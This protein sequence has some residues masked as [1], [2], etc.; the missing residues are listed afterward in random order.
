MIP[1]HFEPYETHEAH[2]QLQTHDQLQIQTQIST[3]QKVDYPKLREMAL[4]KYCTHEAS[5]IQPMNNMENIS[6]MSNMDKS[7]MISSLKSIWTR[8]LNLKNAQSIGLNDSFFEVGGDSVIAVEVYQDICQHF[9]L[10]LDPFV[11]YTSPT[12]NKLAKRF[13]KL[14]GQKRIPPTHL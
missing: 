7:D 1:H 8:H 2:D 3:S 6:N 11:F 13:R 10:R 5:E 14:K 12:I 9:N 4:K